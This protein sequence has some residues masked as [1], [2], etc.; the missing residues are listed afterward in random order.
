MKK[1]CLCQAVKS[2]DEFYRMASSSDGRQ[3]RCIACVKERDKGRV[4]PNTPERRDKYLRKTYG[5]SLADW[6]AKIDAQDGRCVV[7]ASELIT[8]LH[9]GTT[10]KR[11]TVVDHDHGTGKVRGILCNNCNR[12]LGLV[13]DRVEILVSA[14]A[15]LLQHEDVL[16]L[17]AGGGSHG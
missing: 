2:Y 7:C 1:C 8:D 4:R 17:A 16:S 6:Q 5:I 9:V 10:G 15:Y 11:H 14:V 13:D 12:F 3:P